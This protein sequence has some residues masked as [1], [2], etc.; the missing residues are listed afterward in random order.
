MSDELVNSER[1]TIM[2][3][4][5]VNLET[6]LHA[7]IDGRGLADDSKGPLFRTIGRGTDALARTPLPR[8]MP[9]P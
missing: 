5:P 3:G 6:Y 4:D 7:Y 1:V 8:P 9:T 2:K